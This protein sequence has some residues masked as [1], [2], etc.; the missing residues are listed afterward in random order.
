M[1]QVILD[2]SGRNDRTRNIT[3]SNLSS[4]VRQVVSMQVRS[5][6]DMSKLELMIRVVNNDTLAAAR[7][8]A[9]LYKCHVR[10]AVRAEAKKFSLIWDYPGRGNLNIME[11]RQF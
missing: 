10:N 6:K 4:R 1:E 5:R 2:H 9:G 7:T 3:F 11:H 8:I